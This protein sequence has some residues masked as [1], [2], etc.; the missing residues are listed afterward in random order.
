MKL[1][2]KA[3]IG[4]G[5]YFSGEGEVG[6][7]PPKGA[8]PKG[9]KPLAMPR[10]VMHKI[11]IKHAKPTN[12]PSPHR[13]AVGNAA[14]AAAQAVTV[15]KYVAGK[16]AQYKKAV[17]AG[18]HQPLV[19]ASSV[20][21]SKIGAV[22]GRVLTPKQKAAVAKH[23]KATILLAK[24][25]KNAALYS[26]KAGVS[27]MKGL[28]FVK[29][30]VP[31]FAKTGP[32]VVI[33]ASSAHTTLHGILGYIDDVGGVENLSDEALVGI[34]AALGFDPSN[35]PDP[36]NPGFL[37]DGSV[38]PDAGSSTTSTATPDPNATGAT[39]SSGLPVDNSKGATGVGVVTD[40]DGNVLYD[41]S[42]DPD[43]VPMPVRG[44][45][46]APADA[47]AIWSTSVPEDGIAYQWT[48]L[49]AYAVGSWGV[50]YSGVNVNRDGYSPGLLWGMDHVGGDL[51][52]MMSTDFNVA[53]RFV[54]ISHLVGASGTPTTQDIANKAANL[55]GGAGALVGSPKGPVPNLQYSIADDKWFW[56]AQYAPVAMTAAADAA[57][58]QA[59]AT[60]VKTNHDA[61]VAVSKQ[62]FADR[63]TQAEQATAQQAQQA[64]AES[65]ATSAANV[66]ATQQQSAQGD[67]ETQAQQALVA[68]Q[69]ADTQQQTMQAQTEQQAGQEVIS[70]AQQQD[71]MDAQTN[72]LLY[73][74]AQQEVASGSG[75][76]YADD[77]S[78]QDDGSQDDGSGYDSGEGAS[79][80]EDASA[81]SMDDSS[82]QSDD[83]TLS[84]DSDFAE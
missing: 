70:Q 53:S 81:L 74:Q 43:I 30:T 51:G 40:P 60:T 26:Q 21:A 56:Q 83:D 1:D 35:P 50:F 6:F 19:K 37:M 8:Q 14:K 80:L 58:T 31:M 68:Q 41:P 54:Q 72:Q 25:K 46:L 57:I 27:G 48:T 24:A 9:K 76:G 69:Q 10:S 52:W 64:L 29:K 45:T 20:L 17:A 82:Q 78:G 3:L 79:T 36:A 65:A 15:S 75:G 39:D 16:T 44:Q 61:A 33:K 67:T 47:Q 23:Q 59:N 32:A 84:D 49:P 71:Q 42:T 63:A 5:D 4:F 55:L 11:A 2:G 77:G 22:T 62:M 18:M 13:L 12:N 38:D 73:Q 28:A 66:A 7:T 34:A